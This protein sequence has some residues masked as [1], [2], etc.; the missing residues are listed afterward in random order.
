MTKI[1]NTLIQQHCGRSFSQ[2][3]KIRKGNKRYTNQKVGNETITIFRW[4]VIYREN[5]K[6]STRG[7]NPETNK[8]M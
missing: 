8:W 7:K 5:P 2:C 1:F 6:D 4:Y 3:N